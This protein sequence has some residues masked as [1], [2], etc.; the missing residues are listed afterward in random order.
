MFGFLAGVIVRAFCGERTVGRDDLSRDSD[1]ELSNSDEEGL[2]PSRTRT[3]VLGLASLLTFAVGALTSMILLTGQPFRLDYSGSVVLGRVSLAL[4]LISLILSTVNHRRAIRSKLSAF[5]GWLKESVVVIT[6]FVAV[7]SLAA[8]MVGLRITYHQNIEQNRLTLKSQVAERYARTVEQLASE[9]YDIRLG[10]VYSLQAIGQEDHDYKD[11][12]VRTLAAFVVQHSL[13]GV[14]PISADVMQPDIETAL[15][16]I[17]NL[18]LLSLEDLANRKAFGVDVYDLFTRDGTTNCWMGVRLEDAIFRG[19][20]FVTFDSTFDQANPGTNFEHAMLRNVDFTGAEL[21]G[22]PFKGAWLTN[23]TFDGADLQE[24]DLRVALTGGSF[25]SANLAGAQMCHTS[26][27]GVNMDGARL[28][29]TNLTDAQ[30][31]YADLSSA[32]FN[33]KTILKGITYN[34]KTK[35][36]PE[37]TP[38]PSATPRSI[39]AETASFEECQRSFWKPSAQDTLAPMSD[40]APPSEH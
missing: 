9:K 30:L 17:G 28:Y 38:P 4:L 34:S 27:L 10:A 29:G 36:P 31:E 11:Q 19:Y 25:R 23:I 33:D 16:A 32:H 26:L 6:S 20:S 37:F 22:V 21:P 24:A 5:G 18:P 8:S 14:C 3:G 12:V 39:E 13:R 40:F 2:E 7:A 15:Q 35:W 1:S